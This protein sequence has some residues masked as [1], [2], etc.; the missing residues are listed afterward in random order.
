METDGH[1]T[2]IEPK[3]GWVPIDL[4][5]I[6]LYRELLYFMTK[7][8]IKVR[9]KQT[10]LGGL[11]AIIQPA[12]T[13]IVFTL[14][15]GRLAKI[16]SEGMPYPIFVYAGLLPWTYFANSVA[17]SGN[18]LVGSA[19]LITKVYFPRLI[20]P[21]SASLAGLLDFFIAMI[22]LGV[23]MF[24]YHFVPGLAGIFLFPLLVGFTFLSA[25]GAG[26]WLSALNV[27]YRDIRYVIPFLIQLWMFVSPV[28]YPVSMVREKYRWLL[29]LNPMGGII[30][31]YRASIL[32]HQPVDWF[33]LGVSILII[34]LI[35]SSGLFYFR[36]MERV[37]ADVV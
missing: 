6:W 5:E 15:F 13:M 27:Q 34:L 3:K 17:A 7:R 10:V 28:I 23:L 8:D 33:L 22:V 21:A 30:K 16:P 20:I 4:K 36:R 24:H 18:S 12:F 37:F 31:A 29:A 32:G 2:I 25:L 9:Y 26:L 19:N 35:L 14:F 11:W 1:V